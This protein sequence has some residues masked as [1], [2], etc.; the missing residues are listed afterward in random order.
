MSLKPSKS[1]LR[2]CKQKQKQQQLQLPPKHGVRNSQSTSPHV[3]N[4]RISEVFKARGNITRVD[5]DKLR[6]YIRD[7]KDCLNGVNAIT[8]LHRCGKHNCDPFSIIEEEVLLQKLS[9][10]YAKTQGIANALYGLQHMKDN[11]RGAGHIMEI[12]TGHIRLNPNPN[13]NPNTHPDTYP[14]IKI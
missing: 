11:S 14:N 5:L 9:S 2:R 13:S 10:G 3:I 7:R 8:L 12:M 4:R 1:E 6:T